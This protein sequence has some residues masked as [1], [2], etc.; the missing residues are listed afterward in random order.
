MLMC[1]L[2]LWN[3]NSH[4]L[5][6]FVQMWPRSVSPPSSFADPRGH[7]GITSSLCSHLTTWLNGESSRQHSED[8][9]LNEFLALTQRGRTVL[10]YA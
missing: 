8:R 1:G 2:G 9:K 3:P 5:M 10:Q 7:G 6:E 4:C